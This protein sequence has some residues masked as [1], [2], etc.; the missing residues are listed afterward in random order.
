MEN[1]ES[2]MAKADPESPNL[3]DAFLRFQFFTSALSAIGVRRCRSAA[4]W[5]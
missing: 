4:L 5:P 2:R 1:G 3:K